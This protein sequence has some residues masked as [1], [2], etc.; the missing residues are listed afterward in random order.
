MKAWL[1]LLAAMLLV[2]PFASGQTKKDY[3]QIVTKDNGTTVELLPTTIGMSPSLSSAEVSVM[4]FGPQS[5]SDISFLLIL[6]GAKGRYSTDVTYGAKFYSDG[7]SIRGNRYRTVNQVTRDGARDVLHLYLTTEDLAW[8]V[9]G[10]SVKVDVYEVDTGKKLDTF[11]FTSGG[12][13]RLKEF[14]KAVLLT[15]SYWDQQ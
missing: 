15:K 12:V 13:T 11:S 3:I 2:S 10:D 14:A 4:Y 8:L 5:D 6:G 9:V 1:L 7:I